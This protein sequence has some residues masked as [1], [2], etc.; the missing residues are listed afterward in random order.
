MAD[1]DAFTTCR[2]NPNGK[3]A[4][5]FSP[6]L[7]IYVIETSKLGDVKY[8][9]GQRLTKPPPADCRVYKGDLRMLNPTTKGVS[10]NVFWDPVASKY[11]AGCDD[12][13]SSFMFGDVNEIPPISNLSVGSDGSNHYP[14]EVRRFGH[15]LLGFVTHLSERGTSTPLSTPSRSAVVSLSQWMKL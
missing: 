7:S 12:D 10:F 1:L 14:G 8:Q 11:K 2:N 9:A 3:V 5:T 4:V 13:V 15:A 6:T